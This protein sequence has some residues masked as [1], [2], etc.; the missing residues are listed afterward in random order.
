MPLMQR[1]SFWN[2]KS[3]LIF[4]KNK[5]LNKLLDIFRGRPALIVTICDTDFAWDIPYRE[6]QDMHMFLTS[7]HYPCYYNH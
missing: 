5:H 1:N 3:F 7:S 2:L 4:I 6:I